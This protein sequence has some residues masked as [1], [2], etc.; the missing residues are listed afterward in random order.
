MELS[1]CSFASGSSGNCYL[2]KSRE[3]AI[4]VDA[5]ISARRTLK[6]ICDV[7]LK[8]EDIK[9][10][11]VTHEHRDHVNGIYSLTK[12]NPEWKVY[13]NIETGELMK[14]KRIYRDEQLCCFQ[15]GKIIHIEDISVKSMRIS[16]D[17]V[18]PVCYS[19]KCGNSKIMILTDTGF[20]SKKVIRAMADAD[21]I[22]LEA[23][24]EVNMVKTGSYPYS[25]KRRI[26]S[27]KGHLSN[28]EAGNLLVEAMSLNDK[29]RQIFLAHLSEENNFP[30]LAMQTVV[31]ILEENKFYKGR[32]F[33]I[34]VMS[35]NCISG[36]TEV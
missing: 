11:F 35:R 7:G 3:T 23:N 32:H 31:N 24:H 12:Q 9:G 20:V 8:R 25:L 30:E 15:N 19:I 27:N 22:V 10:I 18:N 34:K 28:E 2:I 26:L 17:A 1:F 29:Y 5:G 6:S 14:P 4:L 16:H 13:A 33:D 36:V 21:L